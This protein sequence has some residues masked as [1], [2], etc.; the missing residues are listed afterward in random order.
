[1]KC[2]LKLLGNRW[3]AAFELS[4]LISSSQIPKEEIPWLITNLKEIYSGAKDP[5]TRQ[6]TV[7]AAGALQNETSSE[8]YLRLALNDEDEKVRFHAIV[9]LGNMPRGVPFSARTAVLAYLDSKDNG[10][11]QAAALHWRLT[12]YQRHRSA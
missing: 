12:A 5:R 10:I 9:A 6:F 2:I 3:V 4:K 1:M 8:F 11:V 7:V